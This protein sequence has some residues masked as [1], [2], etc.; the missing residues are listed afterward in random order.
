M[1]SK[2]NL[3]HQDLPDNIFYNLEKASSIAID[4]ETMG[5]NIKNNRLCLVQISTGDN[6]SH[7]VQINQNYQCPNLKKLLSNENI[8]FIF[9]FARF[10]IATLQYHLNIKMNNFFCTKIASKL[11]RTY[12][13]HHGLKTLCEEIVGIEMSK[14]QQSS[15]WGSEKL[16]QKQLDYAASDVLYLH[17]IKE[18]LEN[19]LNREGKML[20]FQ[21][22]LTFLP[23]RIELDL[24]GYGDILSH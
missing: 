17:K 3:H 11:V 23:T 16:S 19:M 5:L 21:Q 24:Q 2:I 7:L 8:C 18:K 4:T 20:L 9:H 1:L 22:A 10:D 12:T 13:D 15:D 14:K 6:T